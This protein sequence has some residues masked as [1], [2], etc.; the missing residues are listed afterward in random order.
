MRQKNT[1][2]IIPA[3][4]NVR[5]SLEGIEASPAGLHI[6]V[7][8]TFD[9]LSFGDWHVFLNDEADVIPLP[10]NMRAEILLREMGLV[11]NRAVAGTA[12]F[13]GHGRDGQDTDVPARLLTLAGDLF[14]TPLGA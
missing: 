3:C 5:I 13:I 11:C 14:E 4:L 6:L 2:L 9:A 7:G 8:G 12:V 1:A 10:A